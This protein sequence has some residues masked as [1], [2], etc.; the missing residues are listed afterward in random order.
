MGQIKKTTHPTIHFSSAS[1]VRNVDRK[2]RQTQT[3][4]EP[5]GAIG[6]AVNVDEKSDLQK[7]LRKNDA[8]VSQKVLQWKSKLRSNFTRVLCNDVDSADL[9]RT[10]ALP[11]NWDS[12]G[13]KIFFIGKYGLME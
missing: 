9:G 5:G 8:T 10:L 4:M 2:W 11:Y 12:A 1:A 3:N 7:K 13:L 6:D